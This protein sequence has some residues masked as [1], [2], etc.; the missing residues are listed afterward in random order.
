MFFNKE[1]IASLDKKD[2]AV[3]LA[4]WFGCGMTKLAPGTWGTV[5]GLPFGVAILYYF[6]MPALIVASVIVFAIGYW[7]SGK[8]EKM[9]GKH[10]DSAIVIDE[11]VGGWIALMAA[12]TGLVP[13]V[14]AFLLFRFFDILKPWPVS[15]AD[16]KLS[17]ALSVM[18]D[19]VLAGIYAA[20]V[21]I[22][23]HYVTS[24]Y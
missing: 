17:G 10:D 7:A 19:D 9:T 23:F 8:F 21:L 4:T 15:W 1:L 3:W 24:G 5:G 11:V 22:G 6:G 16:Q 12:G 2:P 18:L 14:L 20:I 13:V